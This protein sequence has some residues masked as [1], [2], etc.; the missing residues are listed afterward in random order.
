M[1]DGEIVVRD[2]DGH[3]D[4]DALGQRIHPAESRIQR[5]SQETPAEYVVFDLLALDDEVAARAALHR[6]P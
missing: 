1:L 4:F 5:L 2:S 6:A 3:E